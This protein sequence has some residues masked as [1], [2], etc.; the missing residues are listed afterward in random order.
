M[1]PRHALLLTTIA[2][3]VALPVAGEGT[4]GTRDF[5]IHGVAHHVLGDVA[6]DV[7]VVKC[8]TILF[9]WCTTQH[10]ECRATTENKQFFRDKRL[11]R[12]PYSRKWAMTSWHQRSR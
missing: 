8:I 4:T 5:A 12:T 10:N 6:V 9:C 7:H 1:R 3:A 2:L 11:S